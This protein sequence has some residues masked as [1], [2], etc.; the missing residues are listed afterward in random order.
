MARPTRRTPLTGTAL[1][2]LL[3]GLTDVDVP[4]SG[5]AFAKRFSGWFDWTDA[6]A[7]SAALDSAP[8]HVPERGAGAAAVA[9]GLERE[10]VRVRAAIARRIAAVP[11]AGDADDFGPLREHCV[12]CAQAMETNTGP[13]RRRARGALADVSPALARLAALDAVMEQVVGARERALLAT[14]PGRLEQRFERLRQAGAD[15][16]AD[17]RAAFAGE[18]R[19]VLLAELDLRLQPVEGLLEA[20][21]TSSP[22]RHE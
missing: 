9:E 14:L 10:L 1:V 22:G 6:I 15:A 5:D 19:A 8:A 11:A 2:R 17:R 13:L 12:A 20:L 4:A 7:L 21:R 16:P 3:A 18:L